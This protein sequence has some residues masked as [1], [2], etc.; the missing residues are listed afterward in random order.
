MKTLLKIKKSDTTLV[1]ISS[2]CMRLLFINCDP[3]YIVNNCHGKCCQIGGSETGK[4][5]IMIRV[6]P[7]DIGRIRALGGIIKNGLLQPDKRGLCPFK[8]DNGLCKIHSKGQITGCIISPFKLSKNNV[9]IVRHRY[10][11]MKCHRIGKTPAYKVFR[12]SLITM[13]GNKET[14]R[15]CHWLDKGHGDL[16]AYMKTNIFNV[17]KHNEGVKR[18]K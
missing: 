15:I 8:K 18:S 7:E 4:Q 11:S 6:E 16:Y 17:I 9:V 14:N 5:G 13:F 3:K 10:I 12:R 2:K 1:K